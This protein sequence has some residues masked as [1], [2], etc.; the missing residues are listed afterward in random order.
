M[1]AELKQYLGGM[2]TR[3]IERVIAVE[4][5]VIAVGKRVGT[6]EHQVGAVDDH[7][8]AVEA[9][10]MVRVGG[11]ID[12]F[13]E[14]LKDCVREALR[15]LETRLAAE[16]RKWGRTADLRT[17]QVISDVSLFGERL[18]AVE[19]RMTALERGR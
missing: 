18:M 10:I 3:I 4:Q 12:A 19:D 14:R 2:E 9:R 8:S 7:V 1:D 16:F 11:R 5:H 15:D 17:R 13:E 6:V